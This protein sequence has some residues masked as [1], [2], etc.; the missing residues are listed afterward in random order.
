MWLSLV[1]RFIF[2]NCKYITFINTIEEYC[3][4]KRITNST[5]C[6]SVSLLQ[7]KYSRTCLKQPLKKKTKIGFRLSL[8]VQQK[9]CK[10]LQGEHS[11][12][13]LTFIMLLFVIEIFVLSIFEWLLKTGFTVVW[14]SLV[15]RFF[16]NC[17]LIAFMSYTWEFWHTGKI[18]IN[19]NLL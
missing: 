9:Y 6:N 17:N 13:L 7:R 16:W 3:H 5:Y 19:I 18:L 8:N 4:S 12:I 15:T 10:M 1:T 14:F 2:W 11:T